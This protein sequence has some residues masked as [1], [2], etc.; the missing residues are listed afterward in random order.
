[1]LTTGTKDTIVPPGG[2]YMQNSSPQTAPIS[3]D[4]WPNGLALKTVV[5]LPVISPDSRK[6]PGA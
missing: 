4:E 1:V 2:I 6:L 3:E 5:F